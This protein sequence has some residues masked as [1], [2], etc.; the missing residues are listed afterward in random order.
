[1]S[2]C[3]LKIADCGSQIAN[4]ELQ[5]AD[6]RLQTANWPHLGELQSSVFN[7]PFSIGDFQSRLVPGPWSLAQTLL[8]AATLLCLSAA[9]AG[10]QQTVWELSPYRVHLILA[11]APAPELTREFRADLSEG[12]LGRVH[13]LVGAPWET[14]IAEARPALRRALVRHIETVTADAVK[15][16][17]RKELAGEDKSPGEAESSP[18]QEPFDFEKI[19]KVILLV[20]APGPAGYRVTARELDVRTRQWNA[21]VSVPVW[22]SGKLRDAAFRAVWQAFSPLAEIV[23]VEKNVVTLRLRATGLQ[24]EAAGD[25]SVVAVAPGDVFQPIIRHNDRYGKLRGANPVP[26]TFLTVEQVGRKGLTCRLHTGLRTPLSGRRRGR[27][28]QLALAVVP[29]DKSTKLILQSRTEPDQVLPGYDVY[30]HPPDSKTTELVGR[31]DREGS[32][33]VGPSEHTLRVLLVKHGDEFLARLPLVPGMQAQETAQIANDDQ[34]LEAEGFITGLQEELVDLVTRREVLLAQVAK[35]MEKKEFDEAAKL[36]RQLRGLESREDFDL[37]LLEEQKKV[38]SSDRL[39]Q[40]KIDQMFRKTRELVN[41]YL[42]PA[43][44]DQL[45]RQVRSAQKQRGRAGS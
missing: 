20:V 24:Q 13:A 27:Y 37:Y 5:I 18:G 33:V 8:L 31:T 9:P 11:T 14:S 36:V 38:F 22:Q 15:E 30:S 35:R 23:S 43:V 2:R 21:A 29:T 26:W 3:R 44:I 17:V 41:E 34:R 1:V 42:D 40:A 10:A 45:D 28:E 25:M 6:C 7:F 16:E 32:V 39:I 4:C 12:L 19:D